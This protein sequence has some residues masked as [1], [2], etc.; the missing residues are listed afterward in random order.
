MTPDPQRIAT[1]AAKTQA[2]PSNALFGRRRP[3]AMSACHRA[4]LR[5]QPDAN[6]EH[7]LS[8]GSKWAAFSD[9]PENGQVA[10]DS[11]SGPL[12]PL[13]LHYAT[14]EGKSGG[15]RGHPCQPAAI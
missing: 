11:G 10:T 4:P 6:L 7:Q 5:P 2:P 8:V 14:T 3:E 12:K 13:T 15:A 1:G 9:V